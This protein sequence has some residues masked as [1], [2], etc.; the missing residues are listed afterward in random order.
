MFYQ[1]TKNITFENFLRV[2]PT[3]NDF[4]FKIRFISEFKKK[5]I[6]KF[7]WNQKSHKE[8]VSQI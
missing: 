4:D 2:L 1:L 8:N 6:A 3:G 5:T 7:K